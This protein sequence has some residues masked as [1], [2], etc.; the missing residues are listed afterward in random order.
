M[1]D[2]RL[3][4]GLIILAASAVGVMAFLYPFFVLQ[5][6]DRVHGLAAN[7]HANDAP[8]VLLL[9]VAF[10]LGAI[11]TNI[12]SGQMNSKM[13]AVLGILVAMNAVLRAIPGPAGFSAIFMLPILCGYVYGGTFGFLLGALSLLV[14]ALIGAGVGPWIPY[15][16]FAAGWVGM[17]SS[18]LPDM[19]H[20]GR[21]EVLILAIWGLVLG[22]LYGVVMNIWF[23]PFVLSPQGSEMYWSAGTGLVETLKRYAVFYGVTSLW[24]DLGRAGGNGVLLLLFALPILKVLRR[25]QSRFNFLTFPSPGIPQTGVS[26]DTHELGSS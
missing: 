21:W 17:A 22:M 24:W 10:C 8:L 25:F 13:V 26:S 11:M 15:Q 4:N 16:M 3:W 19:R 9:L 12:S 7:A 23:W 2:Y 20:L 1:K 5:S 14:S 18:W 6:E